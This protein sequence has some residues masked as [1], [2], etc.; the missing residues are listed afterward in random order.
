M[1]LAVGVLIL[2]LAQPGWQG[3]GKLPLGR[4]ACE[5]VVDSAGRTYYEA[6]FAFYPALATSKGM[7]EYDD[8]LSAFSMG[9][10][11]R[12][13][14]RTKR[15]QGQI[16]R[17]WDDSLSLERWIDYKALVADMTTQVFLIEELET[18]RS[19]PTLY[20][21]GCVQGVY[22][23][24]MRPD[25]PEM[26]S[27]LA[28]RLSKIPEVVKHARRNL[29]R[30]S[31]LHC[32]VA[33]ATVKDFMPFLADLPA[34]LQGLHIDETVLQ[35]AITS[36]EGFA[37]FLDS[38][39]VDADP[40]FALGY[41]NFTRLLEM[42]HMVHES[43][44]DLL[45]YAEHVLTRAK[46]KRLR[47]GSARSGAAVDSGSVNLFTLDDVITYYRAEVESAEAFIRRRDLMGLPDDTGIRIADTPTVLRGLVRGYVYEPPGPFDSEQAGLFYVAPPSDMAGGTKVH[48]QQDIG[49][50]RLAGPVFHEVYPGHHVHIA[51]ANKHPSFVRRLQDNSFTLQGWALYCEEMMAMEGYGGSDRMNR[52][53]DAIIFRAASMMVDIRLQLGEYSLE[54]A[55]AFM[56]KETGVPDDVAR[57]QVSRYALEPAQTMGYIMGKREIMRLRDDVRGVAGESFTLRMFHD[58]VLSCGSVPPY[59]LRAC[60]MW[61][62]K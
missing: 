1:R 6:K 43:P 58:S 13:L 24:L 48:F 55:A 14:V 7:R 4:E 12:F 38:L 36:L 60:V 20:A 10:I 28:S 17:V 47:S 49:E 46:Q 2:L 19:W 18:W 11:H 8:Q 54:D 50:G 15:M 3:E 61:A 22:T 40:D 62:F 59:L 27:S 35:G 51:M 29:T 56:I 37:L 39:A 25:R 32:E 44:E 33:S 31:V 45:A 57:R 41:D 23:L 53:L 30:P 5:A 26:E 34:H 21:D 42:R 9:Q 16:A 52:V